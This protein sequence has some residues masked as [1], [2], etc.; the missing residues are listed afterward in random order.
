MPICL[1]PV[2]RT[3]LLLLRYWKTFL[4]LISNLTSRKLNKHSFV[5]TWLVAI[6]T[7]D[8][9]DRIGVT[10]V[11]YGFS[12]PQQG[13]DICDRVLWLMKAAIRKYCTKGHDIMNVADM[14]E[15][16][17][18][19]PVRGTTAAVSIFDES[20]RH[21]QINKI[22]HV[23]EYHNLRLMLL[24]RASLS[25]GSRCTRRIKDLKYFAKRKDRGFSKVRK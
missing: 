23:S 3:G 4:R 5:L 19:R 13:K 22:R 11:R 21:L 25:L 8:I 16:L 24:G 1:I 10:I 20:S 9:G 15:A 17:K 2:L 7:A 12:E 18:E 6:T 14:R